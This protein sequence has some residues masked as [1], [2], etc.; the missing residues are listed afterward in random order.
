ME[1]V[2]KAEGDS[3]GIDFTLQPDI[4]KTVYHWAVRG[5]EASPEEIQESAVSGAIEKC[6]PNTKQIIA[7]DE[8]FYY[9]MTKASAMKYSTLLLAVGPE[10]GATSQRIQSLTQ[11]SGLLDTIFAGSGTEADKAAIEAAPEGLELLTLRGAISE[12]EAKSAP[13]VSVT[14]AAVPTA[15]GRGNRAFLLPSRLLWRRNG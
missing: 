9:V 10:C 4:A 2:K 8:A 15:D 14:Q 1:S 3:N 5:D 7:L 6:F 13:T 11:D 12:R